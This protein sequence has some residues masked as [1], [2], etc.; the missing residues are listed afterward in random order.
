MNK[1]APALLVAGLV[2]V[3]ILM[4][5]CA[6]Q[7]RFTETAV[8]TRFDQI[9]E[10]IEPNK[11]G[12]HFK[13]PWPIDQV[14]RYDNRLRAF[15]T[16]FRQL[17]TEDQK[18]VVM[19]AYA[20]WRI[21][22]AKQFLKAVRKE[23]TAQ[24]KLRDL[25]ENRVSIVLRTHP[26]E[27]LV[28]VDEQKIKYT[29]IEQEFMQG[30]QEAARSNYGIELVSVGIKRLGIPESVTKEVFERMKQDRTKTIKELAAAG[31]AEAKQIRS[32][33]EEKAGKILARTEA[34]AKMLEGQGD[35]EA[36]KYYSEFSKNP[37]LANLLK[38][39]ESLLKI[40]NSGQTTMVLDSKQIAPFTLLHQALKS[41]ATPPAATPNNNGGLNDKIGAANDTPRKQPE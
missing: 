17:G 3:V 6:F 8:V 40:L 7:V 41:S 30:I 12:L 24:D 10:V 15:E 27:H 4:M 28:N 33:A 29:Q 1:N 38:M 9:K 36:A 22:D 39:R 20:T 21:A 31:E 16:E 34:Y 26:L 19:T 11:A 13:L 5:M 2:I 23:E 14:H 25:L 35:A 37:A 32:T 18:T